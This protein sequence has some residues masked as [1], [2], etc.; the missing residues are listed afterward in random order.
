MYQAHHIWMDH[1][2][3]QE[4]NSVLQMNEKNNSF[5]IIKYSPY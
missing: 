2:R 5:Y 1:Q 3:K 4:Q